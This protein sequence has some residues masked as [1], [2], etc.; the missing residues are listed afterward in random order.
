MREEHVD[1]G[2]LVTMGTYVGAEDFNKQI[3]RQLQIERKI[4]PFWRGLNDFDDKWAEHQ[5][6]A[7]ARGLPIPPPDQTPP[8]ELIPRPVLAADSPK[9]SEQNLNNLT[10]PIGGRTQSA[11]S[12]QSVSNPGSALPSPTSATAPRTSSPFKPRGKALAAVL[13]GTSR[14][15]STTEIVPREIHLPHDPFVNGQPIEVY[16]YKD[17][18]ECPICFLTYP[19]YLNHTR[20]C[21][22]PICSECFVQIKRPDPHFPEGHNEDGP[23]H[24][25]EEAAEQLVSEPACC[26]YCTQPEFGVTYDPP[27]FR[28]GLAYG[29]SS[30]ALGSL[31][32]AMSS[33]SSLNSGTPS[34]SPAVGSPTSLGSRRRAQSLSVTSPN[35]I[36]T[37]RIRPEWATKLQTARAHLARRAAAATALHTAA[38][39]MSNTET[40]SGRRFGRRSAV[41]GLVLS[42]PAGASSTPNEGDSSPATPSQ[43]ESN[44]RS[45]RP[46]AADVAR[47]RLEDLEEMMLME[48]IRLS[49]AAEEERKRKAEKEGKKEAK[50][51]VKE[52][53]KA[54]KAAVR[55]GEL[56]ESGD[57]RSGHSSASGSSLSLPGFGRKRGNSA[58]S[59]L[60]VEA[61][62][63]SAMAT[64]S[65]SG[66]PAPDTNAKDK[67]KGVDRSLSPP[68]TS[69]AG[70]PEA[71]SSSAA[72][73]IPTPHQPAGPSHL[74]QMSSASSVSS[75]LLESQPGSYNPTSQLQDPRASGLSLGSRSN[76]SEDGGDNDRDPSAS[77]EPMFNFRSLAEVV[78]VSI[79]GEHAGKRLSQ[80][81]KESAEQAGEPSG[82]DDDQEAEEERVEHASS[83]ASSD[84]AGGI[85]HSVATLRA[86]STLTSQGEVSQ[87]SGDTAVGE[88]DRLA[89]PKVTITPDTPAAFDEGGEDTKQLGYQIET[90]VE[91]QREVV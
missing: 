85:E 24:D 57:G 34:Q 47:N 60:R 36:T 62:V 55:A 43:G 28:R 33:S 52:D 48:A 13:G 32:T 86:D 77:T 35:V 63:A 25:P 7:A 44:A 21:D 30:T 88:S 78:G 64:S 73:P 59:N 38:F 83:P 80:I 26:P 58:A 9:V 31:G 56:Y 17:A 49:L 81:A 50:K 51:R 68:D 3:V 65:A 76:A 53:R 82:K 79:E 74:R 71:G 10:V 6:I 70:T 67:G 61:S 4:A 66:S 2:Y 90:A 8:D 29:M 41:Q 40:R 5:I 22:Q 87:M 39:L 12:D 69:A 37:D 18:T 14:N 54:A 23:N 20:C 46:S 19:P 91:R 75:S 27:P 42:G 15:G 11:A 89:P 72:W 16:L 1:G 84:D 45:G